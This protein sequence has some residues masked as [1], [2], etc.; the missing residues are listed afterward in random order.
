VNQDR[1]R[2]WWGEKQQKAFEDLK[3]YI[4]HLTTLSPLEQGTPLLL[5]VAAAPA[6]VNASLVQEREIEGQ[7][8]Q[9]P[10]YYV[11]EALTP[12][13]AN[14]SEMEKIVY[15]IVMAYRKLRHYFQAHRIIVPS[16]QPLRDVLRNREASGRIGKWAAELNEYVIDFVHRTSIQSQA[17][18]DFIADWTP[19]GE[20]MSSRPKIRSGR[21]TVMG[22]GPQQGLA[23]QQLSGHL[24][25]SDQPSL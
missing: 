15:A 20:N 7:K 3:E 17:L 21:Y 16:S 11:S 24:Q 25:G 14:Y 1:R 10:V 8:K 13:K 2:S 18:E 5:Y 4:V 19:S 6:V 9:R 23:Q 22:R 12:M